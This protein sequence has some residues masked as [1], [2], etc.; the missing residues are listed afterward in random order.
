MHRECLSSVVTDLCGE[1][2]EISVVCR[3]FNSSKCVGRTLMHVEQKVVVCQ[4][5]YSI[6]SK[7]R[8]NA[9]EM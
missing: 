5:F 8:C 1:K 4:V 2:E 7:E 3:V 9:L 6:R